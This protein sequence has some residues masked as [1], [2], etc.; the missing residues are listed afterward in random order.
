MKED[1]YQYSPN[2]AE[3]GNEA[4]DGI[5]KALKKAEED[6]KKSPLNNLVEPAS[7]LPGVAGQKLF[8]R[9][10]P[11]QLNEYQSASELMRSISEEAIRWRDNLPNKYRPAILAVLHGGIQIQVETLS[12]ISFHGIR[13]A[14]LMN[15]A[16]CAMFAHQSTVQLLCYAEEI[17][18]EAPPKNPIGFIWP[19]HTVEV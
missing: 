3:L 6:I 10:S 7:Q 8:E 11:E 18:D 15:G 17:I 16:P 1:V 19:G 5:K 2:A 4:K 14:G 13:I 9:M 12:Q